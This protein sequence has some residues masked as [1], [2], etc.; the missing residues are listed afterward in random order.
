[1]IAPA[2]YPGLLEQRGGTINDASCLNRTPVYGVIRPRSE[3]DVRQALTFARAHRL[4]V[5]VSGT[6]HA[7]GGQATSPGGLILDMRGIHAVTVDRSERTVRVGAGATWRQVLETLHRQG[8]SVAAMPSTDILSVGG[9]V[10]VNAHGADFRVGSLASTI[11]SLRLMRA[12]GTVVDLDRRSDPDLFRAV[13]GGY[14][15]FGVILEVELETVANEMYDHT[16][17]VIPAARYAEVFEKEIVPDEDYR[18]AYAHLSTSP[19]TLLEEAVVY[20][21]RRTGTD[22]APTLPLADDQNSRVGRLVLNLARHGGVWQRM[23]WAGQR[24]VL[25]HFRRCTQSRNEALPAA[26]A[27]L[28]SRNQAMYNGLGLLDNKLPQFTD[29]LQEYFL[30][31][32]QLAPFLAEAAVQLREH[33]AELLSASIRSVR[34]GEVML[35]YAPEHRLS[36]VLYLSQRVSEAGN[37]DMRSLTENLVDVALGHG[38][39]FYLPYQQFY[40]RDQVLRAYPML[41]SFFELKRR[42]DPGL[43]FM[44]SLYSRYA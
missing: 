31:P 14:G 1:M 19:A 17:R 13:V 6:R 2:S 21:Y 4:K 3:D 29:V 24:H 33:D 43:L 11:R 8:R 35:D 18:M 7:L 40:S 15:L 25:P 39:T 20:A 9:T 28:V 22:E 38:G 36:V 34:K 42:H 30:P 32:D 10:S 16:E 12:D 44:N 37:R 41:E 5:S 27:C 26:E 23:R